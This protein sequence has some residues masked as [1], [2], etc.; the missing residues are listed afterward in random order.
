MTNYRDIEGREIRGGDCDIDRMSGWMMMGM[1]GPGLASP[2]E[3]NVKT[4][5]RWNG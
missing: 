3:F 1:S 4:G 5:E 2:W